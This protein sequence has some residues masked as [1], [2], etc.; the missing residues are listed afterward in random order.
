MT[1]SLRWLEATPPLATCACTGS[2]C[3]F[4]GACIG[5][6]DGGAAV[7]RALFVGSGRVGRSA[8][9]T[10]VLFDERMGAGEEDRDEL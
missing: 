4:A 2:M 6:L 1:K 7:L 8:G 5:F 3:G 10:F 9:A